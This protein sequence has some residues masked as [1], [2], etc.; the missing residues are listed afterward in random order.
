MRAV[1]GAV[2]CASVTAALV[3]PSALRFF[4]PPPPP[5]PLADADVPT[6]GGMTGVPTEKPRASMRGT[7]SPLGCRSACRERAA[8]H[9]R[10]ARTCSRWSTVAVTL[11]CIGALHWRCIGE[12][13]K[14]LLEVDRRRDDLDVL[15]RELRALREHVAVEGYKHLQRGASAPEGGGGISTCASTSPLRTMH[16]QPS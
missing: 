8:K 4:P 5:P 12:G 11:H 2:G 1:I 9:A 15:Q 7:R 13:Y 10:I 6:A 16:A 14:H 3:P